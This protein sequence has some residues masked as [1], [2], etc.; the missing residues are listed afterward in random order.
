MKQQIV[1]TMAIALTAFVMLAIGGVIIA[2]Q[3]AQAKSNAPVQAQAVQSQDN[4]QAPQVSQ[5]VLKQISDREAQYQ[6]LINRANAQLEQ[7]MKDEKSLQAEV[8]GLK[9]ANA[10]Q[11]GQLAAQAKVQ[12]AILT[13]QQAA[14]VASDYMHQKDLYAVESVH[15]YNTTAYKVTFSSG[16]IVFV[17][18][19]G[20]IM[21]AQSAPAAASMASASSNSGSGASGY[22]D[23]G[24]NDH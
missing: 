3:T 2:K 6:A 4:Q 11:A 14:Q 9:S 5:D 16:A 17:S 18:S 10:Q 1:L 22:A 23:D 7:A 21:S 19:Y 13:P 12:P 20:E 24:E 8:D 15:Y